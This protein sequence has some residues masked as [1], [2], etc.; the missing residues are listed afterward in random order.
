[1]NTVQRERD[2]YIMNTDQREGEG[3]CTMNMIL[4]DTD[5][6]IPRIGSMIQRARGHRII[7]TVQKDMGHC[8]MY[9]LK[10]FRGICIMNRVPKDMGHSIMYTVQK[11]MGHCLSLIHI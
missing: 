10:K 4:R 9:T 11:Y 8:I 6:Y 7:Y 2:F 3:H 1:M 5:H